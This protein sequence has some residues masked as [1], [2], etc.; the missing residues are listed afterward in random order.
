VNQALGKRRSRREH[1][2]VGDLPSTFE[3]EGPGAIAG[4][5]GVDGKGRH[6]GGGGKRK[7][8]KGDNPFIVGARSVIRMNWRL[9]RSK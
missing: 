3:E 5:G 9:S 8:E 1:T 6:I 7:S 2:F 4:V